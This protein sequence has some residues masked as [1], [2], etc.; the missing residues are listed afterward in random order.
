MDATKRA[1]SRRLSGRRERR[2]R[3]WDRRELFESRL[4]N[5]SIRD[6]C[7]KLRRAS[8]ALEPDVLAL[9]GVQEL[10]P[11]ACG[12]RVRRGLADRLIVERRIRCAAWINDLPLGARGQAPG[13]GNIQ[14]VP[15]D[16]DRALTSLDQTRRVA[17]GAVEVAQALE[18]LEE[19]DPRLDA[20]QRAAVVQRRRPHGRQ[21][22]V[23]RDRASVQRDVV[24]VLGR[25]QLRPRGRADLDD[26]QVAAER[27]VSAVIVVPGSVGILLGGRDVVPGLDL[28]R[29]EQARA[30]IREGLSDVDHVRRRATARPT[31]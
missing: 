18:L 24:L 7:L 3:M 13:A 30:G 31:T 23:G 9:G 11:K 8:V 6:H 20:C 27:H 16:H 15:V 22:G 21:R 1:R 14:I 29:G 4:V 28:V 12:R 25:L 26:L 5:G 2:H 10:L 19:G 17:V